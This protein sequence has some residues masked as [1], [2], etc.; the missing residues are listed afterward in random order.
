MV[1][2]VLFLLAVLMVAFG[3]KMS[4]YTDNVG[5]LRDLDTLLLSHC[6][7]DD[8]WKNSEAKVSW[9]GRR[10]GTAALIYIKSSNEFIG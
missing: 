2:A 1:G 7:D 10:L 3:L 9:R 5:E 8:D 4:S 6:P